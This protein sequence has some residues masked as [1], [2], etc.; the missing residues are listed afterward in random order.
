MSNEEFDLKNNP[1]AELA[2]LRLLLHKKGL[3]YESADRAL[4]CYEMSR[5]LTDDHERWLLL[6]Y[7]YENIVEDIYNKVPIGD[8]WRAFEGTLFSL[9]ETA[10][11]RS[12]YHILA[13]ALEQ[14][15]SSIPQEDEIPYNY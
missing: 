6:D 4:D 7:G 8:Q 5:R 12:R 1:I 3:E 2:F 14:R 13:K 9:K 15:E 10:L 11:S